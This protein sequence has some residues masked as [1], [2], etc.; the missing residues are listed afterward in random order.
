MNTI[1]W[2]SL[3]NLQSWDKHSGR[4]DLRSDIPNVIIGDNEIGKSVL[5]KVITHVCLPKV[6]TE[7]TR[8][9]LIRRDC[10][11][12]VAVLKLSNDNLLIFELHRKY[13]VY[14]LRY[15]DGQELTWRQESM[16][17]EI[18][19]EL[20]FYIDE[21]N[22]VVL[23]IL[24]KDM[25]VPFINTSPETN[26]AI[27][28]FV[29]AVPEVSASIEFMDQAMKEIAQA[30]SR[31]KPAVKAL[32]ANYDR[33]TYTEPEGLQIRIDKLK[34]IE[35]AAANLLAV[36]DG[37]ATHRALLC[38]VP[39]AAGY[40]LGLVERCIKTKSSLRELAAHV[41]RYRLLA[42]QEPAVPVRQESL[43][44]AQTALSMDAMLCKITAAIR[45][46][47]K[48]SDNS[49][50]SRANLTESKTAL[51]ALEKELGRCPTCG[52]RFQET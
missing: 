10:D 49:A 40:D 44:I 1:L 4:V 45:E 32:Q 3:M 25:P 42:K 29:T 7:W 24:H 17:E 34:L 11:A 41:G 15:P 36:Q 38:N 51:A 16:P 8:E 9:S 12:G 52:A 50:Q 37:L 6:E 19:G 20:N 22:G 21:E 27:L 30:I 18:R 33:L 5:I 35:T 28:K 43:E 31:L 2:Y 47:E 14:R 46:H 39:R 23:N 13:L 26:A 48:R